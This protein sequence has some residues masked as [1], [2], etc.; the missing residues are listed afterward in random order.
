MQINKSNNY[1]YTLAIEANASIKA[2]AIIA[3]RKKKIPISTVIWEIWN[4]CTSV[5]PNTRAWEQQEGNKKK[6]P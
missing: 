5:F 1:Y 4:S 3:S 2:S 6:R